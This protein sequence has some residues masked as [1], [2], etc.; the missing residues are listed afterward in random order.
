MKRIVAALA[1]TTT[2]AASTLAA[3]P[4]N[5]WGVEGHQIV[6]EVAQSELTASATKQA[7]ELLGGASLASVASWADEHKSSATAPWHYINMGENDCKYNASKNG[8]GGNNVIDAIKNQTAILADHS[9]SESE[10]SDALKYV[11]HFVGDIEQPLHA[12]YAKDR[13]GNSIPVTYQGKT[14]NL[15]A[16]WDSGLLT[17]NT[18]AEV[19]AL[20]APDLGG[21]DPVG[22]AEA[23]CRLARTVYPASSKIDDAYVEKFR[24]VVDSQLRLGGGRLARLLDSTLK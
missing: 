18:P 16:L 21:T 20:P 23:S 12:G 10:R 17:S 15:H 5:A 19:K 22:W 3:A 8:N 1:A 4:S 13:G 24:P 6:A 2:I 14:T 11:V 9:R 7:K